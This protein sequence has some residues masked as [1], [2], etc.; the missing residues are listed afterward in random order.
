MNKANGRKAL[1]AALALALAPAAQALDWQTDDGL[2]VVLN[3]NITVGSSWRASGRDTKL[4]NPN[5]AILQ[6]ITGAVGG[7]TDDGDLNYNKN[8]AFS[9][10]GRVLMD[11]EVKKNGYGAFIRGK[12]W[13]DYALEQRGV[14]HGNFTNG[15]V[16]GAQLSDKGFENLAKFSGA[17]ILDYYVYGSAN[18]ADK[19]PAKVKVGN[20]VLNWGES[21]FI[22]GLNQINPLDVSALRKP[23]TEIKEVLL[24]VGMVSANVGLPMGM[25]VEGFYQWQWKNSVV[26][27]CG[28][29]WLTVD[30][31][32]GPNA[33]NACRGGYLQSLSAAQ[34]AQLGALLQ[35]TLALGDQGAYQAGA[36]I[37]A[38]ATKEASDSGQWGLSFRFPV[39]SIDTE[40]GL[41][42]MNIHSRTPYLSLVQGNSPFPLTTRLLGAAA[43]QQSAFWEY[44]ENIRLYGIS[45]ATTLFGVSVAGEV[46]YSP[47]YPVQYAPGDL[48]AGLIY[49]SSPAAL[50][51]LG[52]PAALRPLIAT[53]RG[54]LTQQFV[55]TPAGGI[56]SGYERLSK[57]QF[58]FNGLQAFNSVLGAQTLT[59]VGEVGM[60]WAGV[61]S[62]TDGVRYGR[63][64]VF[65]T[66]NS[67]TYGPV[68]GLVGGC[69]LLNTAGQTGCEN[70]GFVSPYSWGYRLRGQLAYDNTFDTG[71]TVK[72]SLFW[73]QDVK[74]WSADGQF[75][76]GRQVLG[77]GVGFEY[78]KRYTLEFNYVNYNLSAKWDPLRDRDYYAVVAGVT[79]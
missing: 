56:V 48:I 79:F 50:A 55:S 6:G 23:G 5:N 33:Q 46:S 28:T 24:P 72:P 11:L 75:N 20:H 37:P 17:E 31:S 68:P 12:A 25:S 14:E 74:G 76:E 2:E 41:Y 54:P 52:V 64:F 21:L 32:V 7:N 3:T 42:G 69:P 19:Y 66:A 57:T 44:P 35:T 1:A 29:Y 26:D 78:Q 9:T 70:A 8:Q 47:N 38:T 43:T 59:V 71:V 49:G 77:L 63:A 73:S 4:L 10:L 27:G 18:I 53:Y 61:P 39:E 15:Y 40:F 30:G 13:Y 65:G 22:Q 58:Q 51:L 45:A 16:P 36:Y 60:Q 62:N 67:P 34:A